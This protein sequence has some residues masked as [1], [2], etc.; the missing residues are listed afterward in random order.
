[1]M[2]LILHLIPDE[3]DPYGIVRPE[4]LDAVPPVATW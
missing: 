2:L 3:D 1:M 4:L